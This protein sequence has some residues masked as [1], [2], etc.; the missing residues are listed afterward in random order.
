MRFG[1]NKN[2]KEQIHMAVIG[3]ESMN[4]KIF[5]HNVSKV[6]TELKAENPDHG[7]PNEDQLDEKERK[8][9][10]AELIE[11]QKKATNLPKYH[12]H[13]ETSQYKAKNCQNLS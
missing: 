3:E 9:K 7:K 10:E 5:W 8:R 1:E 6:L 13:T 11:Q 2:I 4:H 12:F